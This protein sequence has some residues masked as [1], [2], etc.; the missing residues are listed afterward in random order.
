MGIGPMVWFDCR[1]TASVR[2]MRQNSKQYVRMNNK[3]QFP[4]IHFNSIQQFSY[5]CSV[6]RS[7][8]LG[9]LQRTHHVSLDGCYSPYTH[10]HTH[11]K[12]ENKIVLHKIMMRCY[13]FFIFNAKW[14]SPPPLPPPSYISYARFIL[15]IAI[16][17]LISC[18]VFYAVVVVV[19][20]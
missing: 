9:L 15:W 18:V 2:F 4:P 11:I 19:V 1:I 16:S 5:V 17:D 10:T 20:A 6:G 3:A 14:T 13:A 7:V 12:S 8:G